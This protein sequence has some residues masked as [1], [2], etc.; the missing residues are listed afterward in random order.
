MSNLRLL[1]FSLTLL[2]S[3]SLSISSSPSTSTISTS[4]FS[5]TLPQHII[6]MVV[7]D[8]GFSDVGYKASMYNTT[9]GPLFSTP[10][11]DTLALSGVRLESYYVAFLCS[12]SRTSFLS[13]RYPYTN[14]MNDEVI[15]DGQPDQMPTNIRTMA[16]LL[17]DTNN[18]KWYTSAYGKYDMGMTS[19]GCTP[20]CRGFHNFSGFYN[21]DNDYYTHRPGPY[22]DLR[23][24]FLPDS[25][26][27]GVYE[28]TL[29]TSRVQEW[30]TDIITTQGTGVSTFTYVAHQAIHAPQQVPMQYLQGYCLDNIPDIYP[31]RRLAC[32]QM[33]AVDESLLNISNTYKALGIW[34]QTLVIFTTDNGANTDTG[35]SN[36]PLRGAKATLFEGGVRG[37]SFIAGAGLAPNVR[38]TINHE[39]Y[40]LVDWYPTI[41]E[42]IANISLSEAM[43]PKYPYQAPPRPLDGMNVWE[44]LSTGVVSPRQEVLINLCP[45]TCFPSGA[46]NIPGM[47][48]IRVGQYKLIHGHVGVYYAPEAPTGTNVSTAF[49]GPR[50]GSSQPDSFPL[51]TSAK[52]SPPFCPAGWVPPVGSTT[53]IIPPPDVQSCHDAEGNPVTPCRIDGSDYLTGGTWLFDV[54]NDPFETNNIAAQN[55]TIV[56]QLLAKLMAFNATKIPQSNS[57]Q[58]P[59]S[60]P[61][62][63]GGVWTPWR[64]NPDPTICDPNTTNKTTVFIDE[65]NEEPILAD[66]TL[67]DVE[68]YRKLTELRQRKG[69]RMAEQAWA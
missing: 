40:S 19:W 3:F 68:R 41:V 47:G 37:T 20:T 1:T 39:L 31:I 4:T 8:L 66:T 65:W 54:V 27:H 24:D 25:N 13:G 9:D 46:C 35:G 34:D 12:P 61:A 29:I 64:G 7:D 14:G 53:P 58:D 10:T 59:A 32:G 21:A 56:Q 42:G 18:A 50:D 33:A 36:Y 63:F 44:S 51:N 55:P 5:S 67:T 2:S 69:L 30:I 15:V 49:C 38:G 17:H 43:I 48:A 28:T 16:D 62:K 22:L 45:T 57:P 6:F 26:Q 23:H 11:I 52:L 60:N